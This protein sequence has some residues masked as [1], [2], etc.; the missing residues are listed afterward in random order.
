MIEQKKHTVLY[1]DRGNIGLI[2]QIVSE[3]W[4][5]DGEP[6]PPFTTANED[7]LDAL[8]KTPKSDYFGVEQYPSLASKAA[9]IFYTLNKKHL[10]LNGNK[11]LSVA[12]LIIFLI[13]NGK[14]L[15]VTQ[16]EMTSKALELAKTTHDH[17][18]ETIKNDLESWIDRN[19]I[20]APLSAN[21]N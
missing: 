16:D 21:T 15:N 4:K 7:N 8:I 11:R 9:I 10:F 18:F 13:I 1:L 19:L 14:D 5:Q 12:C 6:I 3:R 20:D 2:H 17:P